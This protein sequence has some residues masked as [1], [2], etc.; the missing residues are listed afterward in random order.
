MSEAAEELFASLKPVQGV[1]QAVVSELKEIGSEVMS[2]ISRMGSL[3]SMELVSG[4]FNGHAFV[5]YGPR[6]NSPDKS[7][8]QQEQGI[9]R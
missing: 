1:A 4:L 3:G 7:V 8:P 5:L 9:E 6:E 2:E